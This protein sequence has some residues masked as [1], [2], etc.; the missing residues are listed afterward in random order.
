M[1][2]YFDYM[3][4]W[5][6]GFVNSVVMTEWLEHVITYVKDFHIFLCLMLRIS[7]HLGSC[8]WL[9]I[10]MFSFYV[11]ECFLAS[12]S[13][14]HMIAFSSKLVTWDVSPLSLAS[15]LLNYNNDAIHNIDIHTDPVQTS[16]MHM[17]AVHEN[18]LSTDD[19]VHNN[20]V[21][22]IKTP[23]AQTSPIHTPSK[24]TNVV[25]THPEKDSKAWS[26][27]FHLVLYSIT[28]CQHM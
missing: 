15:T 4:T 5:P 13:L 6:D 10:Y 1:N 28:L 26:T 14:A 2:Q 21:L 8:W 16:T 27:Y 20:N 18:S 22:N 12:I 24:H 3:I 25:L 23:P 9:I 19:A 11:D 17:I 7:L